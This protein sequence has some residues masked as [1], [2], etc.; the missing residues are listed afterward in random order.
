MALSWSRDTGASGDDTTVDNGEE[1]RLGEG[2]KM[3]S[4]VVLLRL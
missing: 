1:I 2:W 3:A 4:K